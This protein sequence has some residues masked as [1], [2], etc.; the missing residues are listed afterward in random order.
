MHT[1]LSEN[2]QA[3]ERAHFKQLTRKARKMARSG[4]P[5]RSGQNPLRSS[6]LEAAKLSP[7]NQSNTPS[8]LLDPGNDDNK[9]CIWASQQ[10][11]PYPSGLRPNRIQTHG[12]FNT[13]HPSEPANQ[14]Q[15]LN[16]AVSAL[17][18]AHFLGV[19]QRYF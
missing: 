7:Q 1:N 14:I 19:P 6:K 11:A 10:A 16:A 8:G 15:V 3:L 17:L 12:Q 13:I 9:T 2:Q 5:V 18:L 4:M